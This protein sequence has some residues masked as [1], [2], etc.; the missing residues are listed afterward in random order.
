MQR[1]PMIK[2]PTMFLMCKDDPIAGKETIDYDIC[3]KNPQ[4]LLAVTENG[5]HMGCFGSIFSAA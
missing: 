3:Q 4:I 2:T 5:G 1:I